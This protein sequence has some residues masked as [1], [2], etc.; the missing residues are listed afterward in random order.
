MVPAYNEE[1]LIQPTL[2]SVPDF[3]DTIIVINDASTDRTE[4]ITRGIQE[5][6][7]RIILLSNQENQGVG[8]AI[9]QGYIE[10][11]KKNVDIAA[12]M[13]GDNQMDPAFLPDLLEPIVKGEAE[14]TKG[15]RLLN[16]EYRKGM[17]TWRYFGNVLLT[18]LTKIASGYWHITD[19]Q[20]GYTA[21][22]QKALKT[23]PLEKIFTYYGYCNDLLIKLNVYDFNVIDVPIPARYGTEKSK[24]KYSTYIIKLSYLLLKGF[25]Y[26]INAKYIHKKSRDKR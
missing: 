26:R 12:V 23:I 16:K 9:T 22:S 1:N 19:S 13:A 8:S 5:N 3:V 4:A 20:N 18:Y 7:P 17:S 24:I 10:S 21:I 11:L 14:Y 6:D 15:N 2:S 25:I